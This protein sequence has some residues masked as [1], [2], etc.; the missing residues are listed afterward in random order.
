MPSNIDLLEEALKQVYSRRPALKRKMLKVMTDILIT[1]PSDK[2][3]RITHTDN[4]IEKCFVTV[5][6]KYVK[7]NPASAN[8]LPILCK[9]AIQLS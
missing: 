9:H 3:Y 5:L 6:T 2:L 7:K 4:E 8:N 1:T